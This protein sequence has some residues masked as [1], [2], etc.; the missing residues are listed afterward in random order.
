MEIGHILTSQI[1]IFSC[2]IATITTS[3]SERCASTLKYITDLPFVR[4]TGE[5]GAILLLFSLS[6]I[7]LFFIDVLYSQCNV[8]KFKKLA[9][10]SK[11]AKNYHLQNLFVIFINFISAYIFQTLNFR[12]FNL[13][14]LSLIL[15]NLKT[16]FTILNLRFIETW[17][18][19]AFIFSNI[20]IF[21]FVYLNNFEVY[22]SMV[23]KMLRFMNK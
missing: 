4:V 1:I 12:V 16:A 10:N 3:E 19:S 9:K 23:A 7:S 2:I 8:Y 11:R 21:L 6:A 22:Y 15:L 20:L 17:V 14:G 13:L 18:Y 5:K